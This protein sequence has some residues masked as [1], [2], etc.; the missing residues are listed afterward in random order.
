MVVDVRVD[1]QEVT[2]LA[3]LAVDGVV[4]VTAGVVWNVAM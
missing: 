2:E 4:S 1:V 3:K